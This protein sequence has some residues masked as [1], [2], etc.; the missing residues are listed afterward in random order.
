MW[1][2]DPGALLQVVIMRE[3]NW[4]WSELMG[5]PVHIVQI[6]NALIQGKFDGENINQR[7]SNRH[8]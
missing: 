2:D 8:E 3:M 5:T 6:A 4:S 1:P 7:S